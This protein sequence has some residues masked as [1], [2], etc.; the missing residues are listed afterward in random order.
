MVGVYLC[1]Y[2][3]GRVDSGASVQNVVGE[4]TIVGH[5]NSYDLSVDV[6]RRAVSR[7][8]AIRQEDGMVVAPVC[9]GR[10]S[11]CVLFVD[12]AVD[13]LGNFWSRHDSRSN[14]P[15]ID[16]RDRCVHRKIIHT[17]STNCDGG[18]C[19]AAWGL[20]LVPSSET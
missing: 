5:A 20:V 8:I 18:T 6:C 17:H 3:A 13:C 4:R 1:R 16:C 7:T 10:T 19:D 14:D 9:T 15:R 12:G 2:I 11:R